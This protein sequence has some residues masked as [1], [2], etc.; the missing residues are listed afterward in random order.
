MRFS[1]VLAASSLVVPFAAAHSVHGLPKIFGIGAPAKRDPFVG[2]VSR[3]AAAVSQGNLKK[4]QNGGTDGM[5]GP[6]AGGASC[7]AG[8]CCSSAVR[9]SRFLKEPTWADSIHILGLVRQHTGLLQCSGLLD[10]LW[11]RL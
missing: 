7:A 6:I 1:E 5:C 4:R 3:R 9:F 11:F 10:R 2:P 8:Y